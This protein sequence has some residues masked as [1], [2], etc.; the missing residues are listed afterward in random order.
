M[1]FRRQTNRKLDDE[2]RSALSLYGGLEQALVA[3]D[4][5]GL[6][7][8]LQPVRAPPRRG[9]RPSFRLRGAG[10]LPRLAAA[11]EG[12]IAELLAEEH[13][14]IRD[15]AAILLPL[16][17]IGAAALD[18]RQ[19][20]TFRRCALELVE[21]QVSHIQKESMALLPMLEELLDEDVDRELSFAYSAG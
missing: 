8:L 6:A 13:A 10:A 20:E 5:E 14:A 15:V 12:D 1:D 21:R 16:A 19:S 18:A 11:G 3:R 4:T 7:R 2:H 9:H 17:K